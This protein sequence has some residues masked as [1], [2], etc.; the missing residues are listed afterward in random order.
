MSVT[1]WFKKSLAAHDMDA[2]ILQVNGVS[3]HYETYPALEQISFDLEAGERIAVVGPNGAGKSTLFKIIAGVL[4]PSTGSIKIFG[5]RPTRHICISYVPQR[6]EVDWD[7]PVNV[8]DAVMMGRT[9][10]IGFFKPPMKSDQSIVMESL[11]AVGMQDLAKRQVGELSGGQQQRMFIA[12]TLAQQAEL[13]L[14]DEPLTGLDVNSQEDIL[15][16]L[17]MLHNNNVTVMVATHNLDLA[18]SHFDRVMLLNNRLFGFGKPQDVFSDTQLS[19]A[20][21]GRPPSQE[22]HHHG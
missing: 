8:F 12:R 3:L 16:I 15:D 13:V 4:S 21:G 1:S 11:E 7:F 20:Y 17:N 14:M 6:S 5:H 2:P 22:D 10:Q 18:A 9:G 19:A